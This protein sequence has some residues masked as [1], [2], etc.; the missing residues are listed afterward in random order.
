MWNSVVD[1]V[2][3]VMHCNVVP[4]NGKISVA[5]CVELGRCKRGRLTNVVPQSATV[6]REK[7]SENRTKNSCD[8]TEER[9]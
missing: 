2:V 4:S 6:E 7:R 5:L 8:L 3:V 1:V 9:P